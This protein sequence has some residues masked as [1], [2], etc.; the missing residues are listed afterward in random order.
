M[1]AFFPPNRELIQIQELYASYEYM[2]QI[3]A[4][5]TPQL[6][7]QITPLDLPIE[8]IDLLTDEIKN[9]IFPGDT[10]G[11]LEAVKFV[12]STGK[13]GTRYLQEHLHIDY[14]HAAEYMVLLRERVVIKN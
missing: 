11:F 5:V 3:I 12:M 1:L 4:S 13:T 6:P 9:F 8:N 14:N 10:Y 7:N 2:E